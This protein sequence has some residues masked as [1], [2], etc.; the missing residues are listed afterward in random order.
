MYNVSV[1]NVT[2]SGFTALYSDTVL[3]TGVVLNVWA[4]KLYGSI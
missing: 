3:E 4:S 2:T 1:R